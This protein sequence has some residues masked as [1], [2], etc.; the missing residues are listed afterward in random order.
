MGHGSLHEKGD[1][2]SHDLDDGVENLL[3]IRD[4]TF[5]YMPHNPVLEGINLDIPKGRFLGLLGPSG[6][7]KST[8]LK[9]IIG[10][11]RP[12]QGY[13]KFCSNEFNY[14][15]SFNST[16]SSLG[17]YLVNPIKNSISTPFSLIGYVPQIESV[18]WN[19]PVTVMEVVGMGIWNRS[20][21]YPWFGRRTRE[22][23]Q[24][25]LA[26]LG[27]AD[28]AKRQIRE[29]SG[30]EQQ[31]VFLAR[32]LIGN[33]QILVLDEPTSGVDYNTRE[34]IFG[35]L[36]DLNLKGMTIILTT[37][38]ISGLGKRL[39]WLVCINK[40]IISQG[41]PNEA[42]TQQNLLKTYGLATDKD[43]PVGKMGD[44]LSISTK[45]N[46]PEKGL[47]ATTHEDKER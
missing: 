2:P 9:I 6:S 8:L 34:K 3:T 22:N 32:A 21:V 40:S 31:R 10:L 20:G 24:R 42:L 16:S 29:L 27:I 44:S 1:M 14:T 15:K 18:D 45:I 28:Y 25:V 17:S 36:T 7:G 39:P 19:F 4:L 13:I 43:D 41:P 23:V 33:P 47:D 12:W 35:I 38:D 46:S 26:S 11:H 30:G 5:G 37:H